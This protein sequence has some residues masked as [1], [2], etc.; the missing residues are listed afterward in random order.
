MEGPM[1][2]ADLL[3]QIASKAREVRVA[4]RAYFAASRA[5]AF[6]GDELS[7]SKRLERELDQLLAQLSG[8]PRVEPRQRSLFGEE[9]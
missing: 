8:A 3:E 6:R 7:T 4:Q 1:S 5:G 9:I 2:R